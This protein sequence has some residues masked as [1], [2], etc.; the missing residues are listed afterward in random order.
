MVL[1]TLSSC[2]LADQ[3]ATTTLTTTVTSQGN[4]FFTQELWLGY[5]SRD[6]RFDKEVGG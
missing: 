3:R 2:S 1:G 6:V 4:L 5:F